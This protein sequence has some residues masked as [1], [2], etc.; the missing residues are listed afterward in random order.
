MNIKY[1]YM[2][3]HATFFVLLL[4]KRTWSKLSIKTEKIIKKIPL[5]KLLFPVVLYVFRATFLKQAC[6][7]QW[8][9]AWMRVAVWATGEDWLGMSTLSILGIP[10]T[11]VPRRQAVRYL[12][13]NTIPPTPALLLPV[14]MAAFL[15]TP[16]P[17]RTPVVANLLMKP[18]VT[19][20]Q[21]L[22]G[23]N[24]FHWPLQAPR[25]CIALI[26]PSTPPL[27]S[28]CY[29]HYLCYWCCRRTNF[30]SAAALL[31]GE[32]G[33]LLLLAVSQGFFWPAQYAGE[34]KKQHDDLRAAHGS[35]Q[36]GPT[37]QEQGRELE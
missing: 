3:P 27:L 26:C 21:L 14:P 28:L 16:C 19:L 2:K 17:W 30:H 4:W 11:G 25:L 15:Y 7:Q 24:L 1:K 18:E 6:L 35:A 20:T 33:I 34:Y 29:Y 37:G 9:A 23:Q 32:H 8:G 5:L 13:W 22:K 31:S 12:P 10:C 36:V